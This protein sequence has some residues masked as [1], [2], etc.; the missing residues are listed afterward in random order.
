MGICG[1]RQPGNH[2]IAPSVISRV[3]PVGTTDRVTDS[4]PGRQ[5][6]SMEALLQVVSMRRL[7]DPSRCRLQAYA[8]SLDAFP[9]Q[10]N[11]AIPRARRKPIYTA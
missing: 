3:V 2:N 10:L 9:L 1:P 6:A 5:I 7:T 4:G 8:V 11:A